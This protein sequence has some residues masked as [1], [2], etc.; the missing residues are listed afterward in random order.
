MS[1]LQAIF[2]L[3]LG[4]FLFLGSI[5]LSWLASTDSLNEYYYPITFFSILFLTIGA[6]QV[7][8]ATVILD[9]NKNEG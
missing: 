2:R 1:D 7:I 8:V 3:I 5:L 4:V 9:R 6:G